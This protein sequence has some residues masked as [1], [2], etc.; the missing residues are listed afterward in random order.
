MEQCFRI[1]NLEEQLAQSDSYTFIALGCYSDGS[2]A[3]KLNTFTY[4]DAPKKVVLYTQ[5]DI[6][7]SDKILSVKSGKALQRIPFS[8]I[9][10]VESHGRK[11]NIFTTSGTYEGNEMLTSIQNRLPGREFFRC[12]RCYIVRVDA[13]ER[14]EQNSAVL[15]DGSTVAISRKNIAMLRKRLGPSEE[16]TKEGDNSGDVS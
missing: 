14:I 2:P 5:K 9:L 11:S 8:E 16:E 3:K 4:M 13:I 6:T 15:L 7:S 1:R 10:Y 12:H